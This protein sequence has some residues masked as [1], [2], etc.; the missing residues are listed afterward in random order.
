VPGAQN[1]YD[2]W[3]NFLEGIPTIYVFVEPDEG[4]EKLWKAVS[5]CPS[6]KGRVRRMVAE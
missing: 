5:N 6:L 4:G 3:G 2:A 1:W